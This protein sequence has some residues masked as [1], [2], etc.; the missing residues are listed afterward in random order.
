M[1]AG[2]GCAEGVGREFWVGWGGR[3]GVVGEFGESYGGVSRAFER[4]NE[5]VVR[6]F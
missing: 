3:E 6:D 5:R 2:F 1:R 4:S